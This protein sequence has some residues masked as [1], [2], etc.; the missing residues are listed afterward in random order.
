MSDSVFDRVLEL[1][2]QGYDVRFMPTFKDCFDIRVSF[3]NRHA[4]HTLTKEM[5]DQ[6]KID[7]VLYILDRLVSELGT[8]Y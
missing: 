8:R 7:V 3:G 2:G 1:M 5:L 6:S 4:A